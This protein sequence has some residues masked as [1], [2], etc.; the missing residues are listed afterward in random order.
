MEV[1]S[2]REQI[3][4]MMVYVCCVVGVLSDELFL[5]ILVACSTDFGCDMPEVVNGREREL[6]SRNRLQHQG[7]RSP[8][9]RSPP[10]SYRIQGHFD[11]IT[12]CLRVSAAT[13]MALS[14]CP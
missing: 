4:V 3:V 2:W 14:D 8:T 6:G 13:G 12:G 10:S 11:V 1:L 7:P 5:C 9:N